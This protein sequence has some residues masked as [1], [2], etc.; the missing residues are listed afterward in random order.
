MDPVC[1]PEYAIPRGDLLHRDHSLVELEVR[2]GLVREFL[3]AT[4]RRAREVGGV[5]VKGP[6]VGCEV[7]LSRDSD[8]RFD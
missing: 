7:L 1:V 3:R 6:V 5:D 2:V 8:L 4:K